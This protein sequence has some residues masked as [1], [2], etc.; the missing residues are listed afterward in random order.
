MKT[1]TLEQISA[2]A[3]LWQR[4]M[5]RCINNVKWNA[6]HPD[7]SQWPTAPTWG[8]FADCLNAAIVTSD[9]VMIQAW[10]MWIGIEADGYTHS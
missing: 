1:F 2:L 7:D 3:M 10:G 5:Q 9:C 4:D 8:E 6:E